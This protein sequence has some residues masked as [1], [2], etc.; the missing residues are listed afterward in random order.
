M[1][2]ALGIVEKIGNLNF[3]VGILVDINAKSTH[4]LCRENGLAGKRSCENS[5]LP[6]SLIKIRKSVR[7]F[8][9]NLVLLTN[10]AFVK[11]IKRCFK[12]KCKY[13][14]PLFQHCDQSAP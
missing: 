8:N 12:F 13:T 11:Q 7:S 9:F 1:K 6:Q 3:S 4:G 10:I 2:I 14:W 5:S